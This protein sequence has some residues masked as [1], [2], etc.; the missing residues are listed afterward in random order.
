MRETNSLILPHSHFHALE[1][2]VEQFRKENCQPA[3]K[4]KTVCHVWHDDRERVISL[5]TREWLTWQWHETRKRERQTIQVL[6]GFK[7]HRN[8]ECVQTYHE[9]SSLNR[10]IKNSFRQRVNKG[11]WAFNSRSDDRETSFEYLTSSS[12]FIIHS[13]NLIFLC[14]D[15]IKRSPI[16][17]KET[18]HKCR[19]C[20]C[21]WVD[22]ESR[23][24]MTPRLRDQRAESF[25]NVLGTSLLPLSTIRGQG[26]LG[27]CHSL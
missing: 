8:N 17:T 26:S 9:I 5:P 21:V 25:L 13:H 4:T 2:R 24:M 19:S 15:K 14:E 12:Q 1:D 3:E 20:V 16:K 22:I 10:I 27:D 23:V 6:Y 18:C 7:V 11:K